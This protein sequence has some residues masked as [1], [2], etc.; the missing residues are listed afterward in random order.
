MRDTQTE[1]GRVGAG[2]TYVGCAEQLRCSP[3][4]TCLPLRP[5]NSARRRQLPHF[6]LVPRRLRAVGGE[7]VTRRRI[8]TEREE[9]PMA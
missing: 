6:L 2:E 9:S 8:D 5:P 1:G 4:P 7:C 3:P